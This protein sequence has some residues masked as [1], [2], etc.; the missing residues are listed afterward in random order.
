MTIEDYILSHSQPEAELLARLDREANVRLL[1]P[2]GE[3]SHTGQTSEYHITN[4]ASY[5]YT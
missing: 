1:H 3:R 2:Y 5:T 4:D